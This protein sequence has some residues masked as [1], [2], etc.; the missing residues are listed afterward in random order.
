MYSTIDTCILHEIKLIFPLTKPNADCTCTCAVYAYMYML[1]GVILVIL[2]VHVVMFRH[3]FIRS[4]P[5]NF[6]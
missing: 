6:L 3:R 1:Q 4:P 5:P 2:H